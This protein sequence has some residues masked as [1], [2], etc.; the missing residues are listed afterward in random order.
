MKT[1]RGERTLS[2]GN[3]GETTE[4]PSAVTV[5]SGVEAVRLFLRARERLMAVNDWAHLCGILLASFQL[6]DENGQALMREASS[7]NYIRIGMGRK[8]PGEENKY[9]WVRV[10][11][12]E[13]HPVSTDY[14]L[15]MMQTRP[16]PDPRKTPS[17]DETVPVLKDS[18]LSSFVIE[19]DGLHVR[20]IVYGTGGLSEIPWQ[21]LVNGLLK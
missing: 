4:T 19:R 14:E 16:F 6:T 2:K 3:K 17:A 21:A 15:F 7:G 1:K 10:E 5:I 8:D 11:K 13:Y 12:T 9:D 18:I 20:A